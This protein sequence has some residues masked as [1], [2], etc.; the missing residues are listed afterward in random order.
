[1]SNRLI[2]TAVFALCLTWSV[3]TAYGQ[4]SV[5]APIYRATTQ[6]PSAR[7]GLVGGYNTGR[8]GDPDRLTD[9]AA[10]ALGSAGRGLSRPNFYGAGWR[11]G[12][13]APA[14]LPQAFML[15]SSGVIVPTMESPW[16]EV[17][18]GVPTSDVARATGLQ[19][20]MLLSVPLTG[21]GPT[22]IRWPDRPYFVP[23]PTGTAF[24]QVFGLEPTKAQ[25]VSELPVPD[26]G[27]VGLLEQEN[28]E[29]LV[30]KRASALEKFKAATREDIED[31]FERLSEAQWALRVV[32]D[33][34]R[35]AYIPCLLLAHTALEQHQVLAAVTYLADAV[36]RHPALF[37]ERPDLASYFGDPKLLKR[38]AR[39]HMRIGD[40]IPC[41]TNYALQ[42]Y[43]AWVLEDRV[44]VK[45][46]L[47]KMTAEDST[48]EM[49][50]G[51][52]AVR[53][54]MAAAL[55]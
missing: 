3:G 55:R 18:R 41:A 1:V 49:T 36:R 9:V 14:A 40:E 22:E 4:R 16:A 31:R 54:A 52:S 35:D 48:T 21:I 37:V 43:C 24:D 8:W 46:A 32:R 25:P 47:D 17:L 2:A 38:V 28:A 10:P 30:R 23:E 50:P 45:D 13:M 27:W 29:V 19:A 6:S 44:R 34:D 26:G 53:D 42:A 20:S 12:Q 33:L 39:E 11:M 5:A 51:V 7:L 15:S